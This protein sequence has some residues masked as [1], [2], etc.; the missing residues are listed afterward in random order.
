M[1]SV[2][3]GGRRAVAKTQ[4]GSKIFVSTLDKEVAPHILLDGE[5]EGWMTRAIHPYLKNSVFFDVGANY[6]WYCLVASHAHARKI[7]A[8]EPSPSIFGMLQDTMRLNGIS[9]EL[10]SSGVGASTS[11]MLLFEDDHC[12]GSSSFV[13]R[14]TERRTTCNI[15][16]LDD[17]ADQIFQNEPELQRAPVVI[18]AD[19]EGFE[20]QVVLGAKKLLS[21]RMPPVTAFI[22]HHQDPQGLFGFSDMLDFFEAEGFTMSLVEH[23]ESIQRITREQLGSIPDAEML[24]FRR[25]SS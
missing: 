16:R 21:R 22:E 18:K 7:V 2:Y 8:F 19:V 5:W 4:L 15:V 6:G 14:G 9:S 1:N 11:G 17:V 13:R 10:H 20:A 3:L 23:D 24:C 12:P 25:F